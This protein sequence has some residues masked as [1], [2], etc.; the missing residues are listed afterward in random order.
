M[1]NICECGENLEKLALISRGSK[2]LN[3]SVRVVCS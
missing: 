2:D 1:I 3:R